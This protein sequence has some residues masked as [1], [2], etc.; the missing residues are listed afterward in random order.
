MVD[1]I[2][3][4]IALLLLAAGIAGFYVLSDQAMILRILCIFAGIGASVAVASFTV[5]GQ[6]FF[7]FSRESINETRKVVWPTK[8][9][10]LQTTGV[11]SLFVLAMAIMLWV[12]DKS[13]EW[14]LYDLVLGW[15]K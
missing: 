4:G 5:P 2:K 14:L 9:E 10:T 7:D 8:K 6:Q 13:L 11:V 3:I 15:K 1:K 12:T